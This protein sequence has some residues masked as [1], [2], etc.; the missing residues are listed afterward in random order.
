MSR[1]LLAL[2]AHPDDESSKGAGTVARYVDEGVRCVLVTATGGEAGDILNPAMD[3]PDVVADLAAVRRQ[4]LDEAVAI[5]GY[6][7]L[8]L[9]GYRDSGMAD[10]E[11]NRHPQ[12][13][14]N[15]PFEEALGK[16][17][18]AIR[19]ERPQVVLGYDEHVRYPHP[20]HI[21]VHDLGVAAFEAAGDPDRFPSAGEPWT[22]AKLYA[23]LFSL[24]RL[25]TLHAAM[26]E[27]GL[28]SPLVE[29]LERRGD[30]PDPG[31]V[32]R[33]DVRSTLERARKALLAHR[34]QVD[35]DGNWFRIPAEVIR[36][37]YP[38]EDFEL[39]ASRVPVTHPETDLF[40]G[41]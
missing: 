10:T 17:V 41:C 3:R 38:F 31:A 40:A 15:A 32:A 36:D 30:T 18:A 28:D 24:A 9:L 35:P 19:A 8:V 39:M 22:P 7:R 1:T 11:A 6:Q 25:R 2:H 21:R 14:V 29:W 12:A 4:E 34:T 16:V 5:I 13:F 37:A 26:L 27:R 23:P 33:I 20:D